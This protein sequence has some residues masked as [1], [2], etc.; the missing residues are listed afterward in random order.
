M[1]SGTISKRRYLYF[2]PRAHP[3]SFEIAP[4]DKNVQTKVGVSGF[5]E[6]TL[7]FKPQIVNYRV[8]FPC[9]N[10]FCVCSGPKTDVCNGCL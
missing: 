5:Y 4:K 9:R 1:N 8:A 3:G 6:E 7:S 10:S 2:V